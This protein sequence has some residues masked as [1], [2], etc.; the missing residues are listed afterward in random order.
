MTQRLTNRIVLVVGAASGIGQATAIHAARRGAS[1]VCADRDR[2]GAEATAA[3]I[4]AEGGESGSFK[5]DVTAEEDWREA[6]AY[7]L[8]RHARLDVL[9]NSAGVVHGVPIVDLEL[10]DWRRIMAVNLDGTFLGLKHAIPAMRKNPGRTGSIVN[11]S[12]ASGI[13]AAPGASAYSTSKA[14]V[15]MLSR[16]AAKECLTNGDAIRV[17]TVCPAGVKTPIWSEMPFFRDLVAQ[18][19][20]EEGAFDAVARAGGQIRFATPD[21]IADTI[22]FLASDESRYIT[23]TDLVVDLGYTA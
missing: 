19:G 8:G 17:N 12:S 16:T 3:S 15:N 23:G 6:I 22:L 21:E 7:V 4:A 18:T 2:D 14:G 20:S 13:K 1:V 10:A 11:V 5:L 9:V